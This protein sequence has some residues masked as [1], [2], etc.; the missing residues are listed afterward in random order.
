[1]TPPP[2][3]VK[4]RLARLAIVLTVAFAIAGVALHGLSGEVLGRIWQNVLERPSGPM[5][6]RFILQPVMAAIAALLDGVADART[7]RPAFLWTIITSPGERAGLLSEGVVSTA[8]IILLG[9]T[10]DTIY[11]ALV[12]ETFKPGE[13]AIVALLLAFVPYVLLRGPFAHVA[14]RWLRPVPDRAVRR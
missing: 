2:S 14:R 13:A 1:V 8:R 3:K 6:F 11:Q 9:L 5:T 12:F 4:V 10:M 7:G